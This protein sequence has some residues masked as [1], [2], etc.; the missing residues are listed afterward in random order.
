MLLHVTT[1][2]VFVAVSALSLLFAFLYASNPE[3]V[4]AIQLVKDEQVTAVAAVW[5]RHV[6]ALLGAYGVAMLAA[7]VMGVADPPLLLFAL[8]YETA[9]AL[10]CICSDGIT[11]TTSTAHKIRAAAVSLVVAHELLFRGGSAKRD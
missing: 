9:A 2:I 11:A 6:G 4:A 10:N 3:K 7:A 5:G 8:I 1:R